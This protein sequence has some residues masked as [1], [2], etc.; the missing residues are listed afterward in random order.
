MGFGGNDSGFRLIGTE[1]A[2]E[3]PSAVG[4]R[5]TRGE[6]FADRCDRLRFLS[7]HKLAMECNYQPGSLQQEGLACGDVIQLKEG[8]GGHSAFL[9]G[10]VAVH[11]LG[12]N[13]TEADHY[14]RIDVQG[15]HG[16]TCRFAVP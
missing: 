6:H 8:N 11:A 13:P 7:L 3:A 10:W 14:F 12:P 5:R 2:F 1:Q 15:T 4:M 9:Q 16:I